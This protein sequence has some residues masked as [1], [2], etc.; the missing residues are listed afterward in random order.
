MFV[1]YF[2]IVCDSFKIKGRAFDDGVLR[3]VEKL[4]EKN[5]AFLTE[6]L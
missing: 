6:W 4:A 1:N 5:V 2:L 3:G